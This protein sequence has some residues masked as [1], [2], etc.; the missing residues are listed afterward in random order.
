MPPSMQKVRMVLEL[1][2]SPDKLMCSMKSKLRSQIR[3]PMK[4]GMI[5]VVGGQ[6]LL[7]DFYRVFSVNMRDLGSPVHSRKLFT[8]IFNCFKESA[9][10]G[11]VQYKDRPVAAGLVFCFL[12]TVEIP[13]A[14]SLREYGRLSPN[15]LLYWSLMEF[16]CQGGYR[17]F[18][19]GRTS[20]DKGTYRFKEQW[21]ARPSTLYWYGFNTSKNPMLVSVSD[22]T[23]MLRAAD[24]WQNIPVSLANL[25][26]PVIR[27][28]ISL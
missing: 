22:S 26:G 21:G 25:L 24:I 6:E 11:L 9:R 12:D 28:S 18:D 4:E 15:M 5:S 23:W 1:P 8:A 14:S 7:D 19:F 27:K 17:Y 20:Q 16:A 2:G 13:W 10:I 3:R